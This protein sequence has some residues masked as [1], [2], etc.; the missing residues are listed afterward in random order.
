MRD[1]KKKMR[2][3]S[4]ERQ[5]PKGPAG[6]GSSIPTGREQVAKA[7]SK[8]RAQQMPFNET[9]NDLGKTYQTQV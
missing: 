2:S 7:V 5:K 9:I 6:F 8:T 3:I 1:K 4:K